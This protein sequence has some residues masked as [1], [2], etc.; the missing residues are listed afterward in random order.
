M[1]THFVQHEVF[2]APGAYFEWAARRN[3]H[4]T[5]S[6]VYE[7][8]PLPE[9][10]DDIDLLIVMGGPQSPDTTKADCSHFDAQAE[11]A[12]IRKAIHAGKAVVGVCLGS[13]LWPNP[14]C[15]AL[16]QRYARA[17][18]AKQHTGNERRLPETDRGIWR[19]GLWLSV[20]Y[21]IYTGGSRIAHFG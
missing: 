17:Y 15:W 1:N 9:I 13:Q 3:H 6:K 20:S 7:S 18:A 21:G 16:A 4:I 14:A 8:Q 2:E 10:V 19:F 11:K 12:L 5:F